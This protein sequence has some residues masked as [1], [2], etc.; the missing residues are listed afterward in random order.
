MKMTI[1]GLFTLQQDWLNKKRRRNYQQQ[2]SICQTILKLDI[3]RIAHSLLLWVMLI[4]RTQVFLMNISNEL[5]GEGL[6]LEVG[7]G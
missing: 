2:Q 1:K 3:A 7:E 4:T 6:G 5:P